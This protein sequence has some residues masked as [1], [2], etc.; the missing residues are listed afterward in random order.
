MAGTLDKKQILNELFLIVVGCVI[1]SL[2]VVLFMDQIHL[3]P[4]SVTGIAVVT[5]A[6]F[7]IP[8]GVLNLVIN[9]PLV[10]IAVF[11]LGKKLLVY[12]ALTILLN[13]FLMDWLAFLPPFTTDMMLASIFGGVV[14][15][16]GLGMILKA[17]GTTGGTTVVGRLVTRKYPNVPIGYVLMAGDFIIITVGS[18]LLKSWDLMLYSLI[19]LYICS[20]IN[21]VVI[22]G[23][24]TKAAAIVHTDFPQMVQKAL[25][26]GLACRTE[27]LPSG[28]VV[29]YC[30]KSAMNKLQKIVHG[31]DEAAD[32]ALVE[33][34]YTFGDLL[35]LEPT[36]TRG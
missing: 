1:Y 36:H 18:V 20:I 6:L 12:T 3:I 30:K 23:S 8:I 34:D 14:M 7:D 32:C 21:N 33:L 31:A 17:G 28:E 10:L 24:E 22:Y 35:K 11:F 4:G 13:S 19:N 26:A 9:I 2:S 15:G 29:C 16:V 5:K 27:V 25:C